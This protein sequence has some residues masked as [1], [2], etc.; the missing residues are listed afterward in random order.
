MPKWTTKDGTEIPYSEIEDDHLLN[1]IGWVER[2]SNNGCMV[3]MPEDLDYYHAYLCEGVM[4]GEE[5]LDYF[6]YEGLCHEA[7][8]R[9]LK[10]S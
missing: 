2:Q 6:D 1:I 8:S 9:K 7:E 3:P 4:E 10:T 5:V